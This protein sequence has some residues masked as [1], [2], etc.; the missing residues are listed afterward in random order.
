M[1]SRF[2]Y[3]RDSQGFP[4]TGGYDPRLV[5]RLVYNYR[6]LPNVLKLSSDLFYDGQ[7][8]ATVGYLFNLFIALDNDKE[9]RITNKN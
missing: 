2:P 5:T 7:L 6:S 3:V 4:D 9:I 1:L 8:I